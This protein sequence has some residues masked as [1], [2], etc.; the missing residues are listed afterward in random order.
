VCPLFDG[1]PQIGTRAPAAVVLVAMC[2]GVVGGVGRLSTPSTGAS[3]SA[4][5]IGDRR[6][7]GSEFAV[8]RGWLQGPAVDQNQG[9]SGAASAG[10]LVA[11]DRVAGRRVG[12][13]GFVLGVGGAGP[14]DP[15]RRPAALW[16]SPVVASG[17]LLPRVAGGQSQLASVYPLPH[18]HTLSLSHTVLYLFISFLLSP[19]VVK[20]KRAACLALDNMHTK[21]EY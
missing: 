10:D 19:T 16:H 11:D 9:H 17:R 18:T 14:V 8:G 3:Q 2:G 12:R 6:R 21:A 5:A 1:V 15:G 20:Q 7:Q 13:V 4:S